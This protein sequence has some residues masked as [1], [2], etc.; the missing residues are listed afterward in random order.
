MAGTRKR[1]LSKAEPEDAPSTKPPSLLQ[2]IRNMWHFANLFQFIML[3]GKAL[4]MDDNFDIEDLEADCLKPGAPVLQD[5][6]L[7]FL[8]YISSHRGL[9]HALFDEY[10]RRQFLAK[11]PEKNLF[12]TDETP[13]R[14]A[15]F[16]VFTKL[17]VLHGM[18][19]II[20]MNPERLR[21]RT[22]EQKDTDQTSWRIEPY[23]WDK[24]DRTYFVLDD[25]RIYRLTEA[26]PP[27]PNPKKNT[28]KAKASQRSR[29]RRRISTAAS[30]DAGDEGADDSETEKPAPKEVEDDGLGGMKWECL[31]VTLAEVRQVVSSLKGR[32]NERVLKEQIQE[33]L[34]PILERQEE[35]RM[36]KQLQREKELLNLEKMAHAKRSS[37][38]AGKAEQQKAVEES[39]EEERKRQQQETAQRKEEAQRVKLERE[40]NKRLFSRGQRLKEREVRR[41]QHEE[42]LAQLSEDSKSTSTAPGRMSERRRL[43]E[44]EKNRKALRE[45]EEE[46]DDWIFDCIC[47]AYGQIDDGSHSVSCERCNVW[48]HS[49]CIGISE[50]EAEKDDFHFICEPCKKQEQ[51]RKE[52][53]PRIIK[54]RVNRGSSPP[55]FL[56]EANDKAAAA[57][58]SQFVVELPS[59]PTLS[60]SNAPS[61][62]LPGSP[63][64]TNGSGN[65]AVSPVARRRASYGAENNPFSSPHPTLSPP[66]SFDTSGVYDAIFDR[67]ERDAGDTDEDEEG[68]ADGT[69]LAKAGNGNRLSPSRQTPRAPSP[70]AT[71]TSSATGTAGSAAPAKLPH[72]TPGP[73]RS[74]E[75][76]LQ[77]SPGMSPTKQA[78]P[79]PQQ[80]FNGVSHAATP[81]LAAGHQQS[82][83]VFPPAAALSPTPHEQIMTPPVKHNMPHRSSPG[84]A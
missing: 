46:E 22:E 51:E 68:G 75:D 18:T 56:E 63:V 2:Q 69:V 81:R 77:S 16:D 29:K 34:V 72:F 23:G 48:Q 24:D 36:R 45:I 30:S 21:E 80:S 47:G 76:R 60:A 49:K 13:A 78:P 67:S 11:A 66:R 74:A 59:K 62:S 17:R 33:H 37:R 3:F 84:R 9:T 15:D 41:V 8:K 27:P 5:I 57:E 82:A 54:I 19:Q 6:G 64:K 31:A 12:G 73:S 35:S 70:L 7:G 53:G 38:L 58:R 44:I 42:E 26:P 65:L 25:N 83:S 32:D 39:R 4:K 43:V 50:R 14:F 28:K 10:T 55:S 61:M 52:Q 1:A 71:K 20:L 40:R 79:T